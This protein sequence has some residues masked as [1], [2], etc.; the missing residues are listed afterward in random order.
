MI[1]AGFE[2]MDWN[3]FC[4]WGGGDS[5]VIRIK[6]VVGFFIKESNYKY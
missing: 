3:V 5:C 4:C 2:D 1:A 6:M